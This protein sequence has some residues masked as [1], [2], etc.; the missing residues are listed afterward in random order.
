MMQIQTTRFGPIRIESEDILFFP[1]GLI[2]LETSQ[3]WVLLADADNSWLAWLQST[4]RPAVALAVVSPRRFVP[5]YQLRVARRELA[6]LELAG[7]RDA[8]VLVVVGK[9]DGA[10]TL[11]LKG[12][13]V[14]NLKGRKGRQVI[15]S[16]EMPVQHELGIFR[17]PLRNS[18]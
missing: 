13:L 15:A 16:G 4:D 14:I 11:N 3:Q 7:L 12:P 18:A 10:L 8:Q 6:P 9:N 1:E 2:G 5:G 17:A